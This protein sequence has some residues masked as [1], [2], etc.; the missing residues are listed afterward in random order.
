M[1]VAYW[2]F[3]ADV[4]GFLPSNLEAKAPAPRLPGWWVASAQDG[5]ILALNLILLVNSGPVGAIYVQAGFNLVE[6]PLNQAFLQLE[7]LGPTPGTHPPIY[8][9]A[10][11]AGCHRSFAAAILPL[12]AP[13]AAPALGGV[14]HLHRSALQ[15]TQ[16]DTDHTTPTQ[17]LP[18]TTSYPPCHLQV[19]LLFFGDLAGLSGA[20]GFTSLVEGF[21]KRRP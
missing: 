14:G 2:A 20:I 8:I 21:T 18:S 7:K 1:A 11:H 12:P 19:A 6:E 10:P 9:S 15:T 13:R 3:G 16:P 5:F 4:D 17:Y